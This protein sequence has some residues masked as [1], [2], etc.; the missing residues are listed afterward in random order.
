MFDLAVI[1]FR[2]LQMAGAVILFGS[3]LF[4]MYA[5]PAVGPGSAASLRWPRPLLMASA[6]ALLIGSLMGFFSQTVV[7]A[8]SVAD[9][10]HLDALS[11]AATGMSFGKSSI[12][13]VAAVVVFL[14]SFGFFKPG[15]GAWRLA[16]V[17]GG[18]SCASYAWMGHGAAS[19]GP[20]GLL[21]TASDVVQTLA[22]GVWIGALVS[23]LILLVTDG[24]Q[25]A[26]ARR[27]LHAALHGFAGVGSALVAVI[28]A[29]GLINSWF[30][31]GPAHL[32]SLLTTPY[33]RLL[34]VKLVLFVG[35]L[36]LA[37]ANRFQLTPR[38]GRSLDGA[39]PTGPAV[40]ALRRSLVLETGLSIAVLGLVAWFGTLAPPTAGSV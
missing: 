30:L 23:F 5:L 26:D 13:R 9:A 21:H 35:M 1:V 33:G 2:W 15:S 27:S 28:V 3:S 11:A 16:A 22:A 10:A 38:L 6:G 19:P 24:R 7:L 37:T 25:P 40:A 12:V 34:T 39:S 14:L 18:V 29:T 36:G 17:A 8:G 20:W 31:V 4:F 32:P